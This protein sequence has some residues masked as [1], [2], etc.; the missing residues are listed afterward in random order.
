MF[1]YLSFFNKVRIFYMLLIAESCA[2]RIILNE[3]EDYVPFLIYE[4]LLI[5][6]NC[7]IIIQGFE[8]FVLARVINNQNFLGVC[9]FIQGN[10][11][12]IQHFTAEWITYHKTQCVDSF[13]LICIEMSD[14]NK[15][16][17]SEYCLNENKAMTSRN[18]LR[19]NS[20]INKKN[21]KKKQ[22]NSNKNLINKIFPPF[23]FSQ[24]LLKMAERTKKFMS[25]NDLIR[26]DFLHI[27]VLF[28]SEV[29]IE[30]HLFSELCK[31]IMKYSE[32]T[33][34]FVSLL[35]VFEIIR[36]SNL[37]IIKGYDLIK[38]NEDLRNALN[39]Y[40]KKYENFIRYGDKSPSN[41][42]FI[43]KEFFKFKEL[44]KDIHVLF[45][46]NIECN[47]QLLLMRY[48]YENLL[49]L[50]FKNTQPFDLNYYSD[51]LDFHFLNDKIILMKYFIQHDY[52]QIIKGSKELLK[53]QGKQFSKI[54]P[55]DFQNI[56]ICKFKEQLINQDQ[57]DIKPFYEFFVKN[58]NNSQSFGF[59][60]SF[61]MKYLI[62]PTDTVNELFIQGNF[63]NNYSTLM[64]FHYFIK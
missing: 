11:I 32:N 9:W 33:N 35:L 31:L 55:D 28:L 57:K 45:K 64:V 49:H 21:E 41:Y 34:V 43:S 56:A 30:F 58:L 8:P 53:Y 46:K 6:L 22:I 39:V 12:D 18:I 23:K 4:I 1:F 52:F 38:K 44:V 3:Y 5:I 54:F 20:L 15:D 42:I 19:Q 2:F 7:Y 40:I 14:E 60:E 47:Y 37:N 13:C 51:F 10:D 48:A 50:Q 17:F 63:V 24:A 16:Y 59:I 29:S 61:K 27:M 25:K 62:Y 26:L 36:K